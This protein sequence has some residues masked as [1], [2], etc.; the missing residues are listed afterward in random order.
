M[1]LSAHTQLLA[2]TLLFGKEGRI[3]LSLCLQSGHRC[4]D[5][6][7]W[8]GSLGIGSGSGHRAG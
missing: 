6:A 5:W 8:T 3:V 7:R 4:E 1:A 2:E